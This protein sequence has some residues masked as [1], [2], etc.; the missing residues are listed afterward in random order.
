MLPTKIRPIRIE[1]TI[2]P[3]ITIYIPRRL[4][5]DLKMK[6]HVRVEYCDIAHALKVRNCHEDHI[7][8]HGHAISIIKDKE[9]L[10]WY[11]FKCPARFYGIK[12]ARKKHVPIWRLERQGIWIKL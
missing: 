7:A 10:T 1:Y 12:M 8:E 6:T 3:A 9:N 5:V 2:P 11:I 4:A